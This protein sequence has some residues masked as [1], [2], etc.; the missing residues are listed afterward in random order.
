MKSSSMA[1]VHRVSVDTWLYPIP[2]TRSQGGESV[3]VPAAISL[4]VILKRASHYCKLR[5]SVLLSLCPQLIRKA[6]TALPIRL[7]NSLDN[8]LIC[9]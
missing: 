4:C 6:A 1:S 5:V 8:G 3:E 7:R 9:P 2:D